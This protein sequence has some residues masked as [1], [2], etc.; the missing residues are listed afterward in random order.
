M[1]LQVKVKSLEFQATSCTLFS[2][3]KTKIIYF[4]QLLNGCDNSPFPK[5]SIKCRDSYYFS[6]LSRF[7]RLKNQPN[8]DRGKGVIASVIDFRHAAVSRRK[9]KKFAPHFARKTRSHLDERV[10][11]LFP[12]GGGYY[13]PFVTGYRYWNFCRLL[14]GF[15]SLENNHENLSLSFRSKNTDTVSKP[16]D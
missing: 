16:W 2:V 5:I 4:R 6:N 3:P 12:E 11:F 9:G 7:G 10:Y 15:L 1:Q 13:Q 8:L 14:T